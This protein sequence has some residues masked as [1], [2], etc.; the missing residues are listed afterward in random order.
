[1][2]SLGVSI[3][4]RFAH[5]VLSA[6]V[7]VAPAT[8]LGGALGMM[9]WQSVV[10]AL[11]ASVETTVSLQIEISTLL[12]IALAQFVLA[13]MLCAIISACVIAPKGLSARRAK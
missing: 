6:I 4:K 5:V 11:K 3:G 1:M 8:I 10:S 12:L 9:L 13:M 2:E 7:V